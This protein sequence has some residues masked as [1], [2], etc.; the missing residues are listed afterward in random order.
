MVFCF[1]TQ[2]L[3]YLKRTPG[4]YFIDLKS[5]NLNNQVTWEQEMFL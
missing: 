5:V 3:Q 1:K 2:Q 4:E